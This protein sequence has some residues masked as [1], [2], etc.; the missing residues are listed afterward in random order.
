M[1]AVDD[2]RGCEALFGMSCHLGCDAEFGIFVGYSHGDALAE[3]VD[4]G[5]GRHLLYVVADDEHSEASILHRGVEAQGCF[6]CA[7]IYYGCKVGCYHHAVFAVGCCMLAT[8]KAFLY[9]H[10]VHFFDKA[11][12][13]CTIYFEVEFGAEAFF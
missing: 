12:L 5:A 11:N 2:C 6:A 4:G 10:N 7:T 3:V 9:V 8:N 1:I 13:L